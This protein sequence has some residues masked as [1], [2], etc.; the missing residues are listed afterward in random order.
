MYARLFLILLALF[1]LDAKAQ[2]IQE[3]V[4]FAI[5]GEPKYAAGFSHFDYVN[6][7]APKGGTLTLAA[8]GTFDNFNR[9]ALRGN[10]AVRTEALYDTLFTTS[11][12]E[13]GSYYPLIAERARYAE[14]YS[15][16]EIALN[17]RARF[18]DGTPITA[19]DVAF[20]FNKFMTEGVP[21]FRLFYKGTT[22]KAIAPLTVRID[23]GQ[24]GK[25]NMLS[26]LSLPVMPEAYWRQHKLSDPLSKPPLASGPY[27]ISAWRMGQ[28]IIYSRVADYWAAD[29]PV[30]RGDGFDRANLLKADALLNAAGWTVKNQRRVNAATGKP[31]RFELLLPAGGN[32]RWVL[33]FQHNLQRLGIVMDIRQVDNSQYSNRRR[34]R[35]YDM[36]PSLWRAMPWPGTDLQISWASDY[37]HSSYNAPGVQS[38]V[39]DKLI[40]QILQ[41]QGNKQKLIPLGR[42]LDRVLTWNNYMLPMW[43]MAQDRTAWWNK[44]S[45]PATRP[46]YSSGLDTWWYD[47]NKAATL[48]ADRR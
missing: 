8:I 12:D 17:P 15:W 25:E 44:F 22:V 45:F 48:P 23:L 1:S 6:P 2:T 20:T 46:I 3:S 29:L 41:W 26:L 32:D 18:H 34:S 28:Y 39:V 40:A 36:M 43:Y 27:R 24:P 9:Y 7:R 38:P 31:L 37:I 16:M 5:I 14:D 30:S 42:A 10:P 19:R 35:D 47:V 13:P 21:Q 4:A 11:D 33:P